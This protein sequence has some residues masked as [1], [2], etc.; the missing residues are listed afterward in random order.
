M[1]GDQYKSDNCSTQ[2]EYIEKAI[3]SMSDTE[4]RS[5]TVTIFPNTLSYMLEGSLTALGDQVVVCCS[6]CR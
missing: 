2:N 3:G 1:V 5:A 4:T 6:N